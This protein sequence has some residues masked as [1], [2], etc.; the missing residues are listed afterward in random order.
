MWYSNYEDLEKIL[1]ETIELDKLVDEDDI[2]EF[3]Q[4][5]NHRVKELSRI[6]AFKKLIYHK[7]INK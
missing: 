6:G 5:V 2:E 7:Q 3:W 4:K 1:D